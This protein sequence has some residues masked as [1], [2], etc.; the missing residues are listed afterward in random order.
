MYVRET[1]RRVK[2]SMVV[3]LL[4]LGKITPRK[5]VMVVAKCKR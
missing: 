5:E 3:T 4:K 1:Q 2:E